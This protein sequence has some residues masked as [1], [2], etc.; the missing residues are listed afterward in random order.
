VQKIVG[1]SFPQFE[2]LPGFE[3]RSL[4]ELDLNR[5][6]ISSLFRKSPVVLSLDFEPYIDRSVMV[7][8]NR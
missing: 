6:E 7:V 3:I 1:K 2:N 8:L 5:E 4:R